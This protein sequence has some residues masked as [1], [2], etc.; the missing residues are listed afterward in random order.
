MNY[1]YLLFLQRLSLFRTTPASL[2]T[3]LRPLPWL[4]R[5]SKVGVVRVVG[6]AGEAGGEAEVGGS[7]EGEGE[8]TITR[9]V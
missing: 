5:T 3:P 4:L 8:K 2:L 1:D 7:A 6:E 9:A